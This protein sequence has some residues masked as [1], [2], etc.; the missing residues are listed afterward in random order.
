MLADL[1]DTVDHYQMATGE[2]E[3][4]DLQARGLY[5]DHIYF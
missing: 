2:P 5:A 4:G 3:P 1:A